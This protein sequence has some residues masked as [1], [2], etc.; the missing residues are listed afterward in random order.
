MGKTIKTSAVRKINII[1]T[2]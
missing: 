1:L 2:H